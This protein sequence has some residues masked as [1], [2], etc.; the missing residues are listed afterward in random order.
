MDAGQSS[1]VDLAK[2]EVRLRKV[3]RD[4]E[5]AAWVASPEELDEFL[6]VFDEET[7]SPGLLGPPHL[8]TS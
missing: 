4:P 1:R 3:D 5:S 7:N 8:A 2:G 6:M